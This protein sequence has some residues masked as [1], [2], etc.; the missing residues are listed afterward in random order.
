MPSI[1]V[2]DDKES[3]RTMLSNVLTEEG[4]QVDAA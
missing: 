3:M 1:L 4:Y 2:I